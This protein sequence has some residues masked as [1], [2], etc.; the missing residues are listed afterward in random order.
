MKDNLLCNDNNCFD[1]ETSEKLVELASAYNDDPD[2]E[3]SSRQLIRRVGAV[4]GRW[5]CLALS[6]RDAD[7]ID[8]VGVQAFFALLPRSSSA[9]Q[10]L[11]R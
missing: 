11:E 9:W 6:F 10:I 1:Y 4:F 7:A 2:N 8:D 3:E 5:Q